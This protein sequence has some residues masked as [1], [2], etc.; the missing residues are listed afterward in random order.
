MRGAVWRGRRRK[1]TKTALRKHRFEGVPLEKENPSPPETVVTAGEEGFFN[2]AGGSR[3]DGSILRNGL[4][5]V[6][7]PGGDAAFQIPEFA[8][9]GFLQEF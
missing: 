8:E 6:I 9:S 3:G 1:S 2:F 5:D 4:V 7:R